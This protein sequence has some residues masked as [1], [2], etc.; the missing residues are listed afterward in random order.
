MAK[1]KPDPNPPTFKVTLTLVWNE[2]YVPRKEESHKDGSTTWEWQVNRLTVQPVKARDKSHAVTVAKRGW[3]KLFGDRIAR[4]TRP[5]V[6][7]WE[8]PWERPFEERQARKLQ[9][10]GRI[11]ANRQKRV[12]R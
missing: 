11:K 10:L 8:D 9:R 2:V 4:F 5:T 7:T 6:V 1:R 3:R 12:R